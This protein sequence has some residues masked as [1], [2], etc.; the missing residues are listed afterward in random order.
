MPTA[1]R[2]PVKVSGS[3]EGTTMS[4]M[5]SR[6]DAPSARAASTRLTGTATTA[7]VE[8]LTGLDT[9]DPTITSNQDTAVNRNSIELFETATRC[10][11]HLKVQ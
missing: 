2:I 1:S 3:A 11:Q 7:A 6:R 8:V 4:R 9:K 10:V 5:T